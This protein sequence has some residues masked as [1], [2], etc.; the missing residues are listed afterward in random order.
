MSEQLS[1]S[2]SMPYLGC[3]LSLLLALVGS[4]GPAWAAQTTRFL[5]AENAA[6]RAG[7]GSGYRSAQ[8][9]GFTG[10]G[11]ANCANNVT[12]FIEWRVRIPSKG[13]AKGN[14]TI[15]FRFANGAS[16][17]RTAV[18]TYGTSSSPGAPVGMLSFPASGAWDAWRWSATLTVN[19]A[20]GDNYIRIKGTTAAG[21]PNIDRLDVVEA[22]ATSEDLGVALAEAE[23]L[24]RPAAYR[25]GDARPW[26]YTTAFLMDAIYRVYRRTLDPRYLAYVK[27]WADAFIGPNG[28]STEGNIYNDLKTNPTDPTPVD[29]WALDNLYP[30]TVLIDVYNH[31]RQTNYRVA[32]QTIRNRFDKSANN[33]SNNPYSAVNKNP[34]PTWT[35]LYRRSTPANGSILFHATSG[36][37][38]WLDGYFM[39]QTF[40]QAYGAKFGGPDKTYADDQNTLHAIKFDQLMRHSQSGLLWHGWDQSGSGPNWLQP[41]KH[42]STQIW[43]RAV[44][45]YSVGMVD[46]LDTLSRSHPARPKVIAILQSL[47]ASTARYQQ[48][49]GRWKQLMAKPDYPYNYDETS[50]SAMHTYAIKKAIRKQ[51]VSGSTSI[52]GKSFSARAANGLAGVLDKV[53]WSTDPALSADLPMVYGGVIGTS[54]QRTEAEYLNLDSSNQCKPSYCRVNNN[55]V[56]PAVIRAWEEWQQ[57]Q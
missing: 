17:D 25:S 33:A 29:P 15:R 31:Y 42:V 57:A 46:V 45:W 22:A 36:D 6:T 41:G 26:N 13:G 30:G 9:A 55:H 56:V 38:V 49:T 16:A 39:G 10:M 5:Q 34:L 2:L 37:S 12:A 48:P 19:L 53:R 28:T 24:R 32:L 14:R 4:G 3:V 8:H 11:Y 18:V 44:G 47:L 54:I 23:M 52:N 20:V 7:C 21:L 35:T 51:Y 1:R 43:C 40:L 50:C 27:S